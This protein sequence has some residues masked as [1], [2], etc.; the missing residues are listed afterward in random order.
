MA[1][2]CCAFASVKT[3]DHTVPAA[4][5][6]LQ[7]AASKACLRAAANVLDQDESI[8]IMKKIMKTRLY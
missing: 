6:P 1:I 2:P 8:D 5:L 7:S 3:H 4:R